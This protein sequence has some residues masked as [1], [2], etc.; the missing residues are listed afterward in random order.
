MSITVVVRIG[1]AMHA[2]D[3]MALLVLVAIAVVPFVVYRYVAR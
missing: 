1:D 3:A 2:F